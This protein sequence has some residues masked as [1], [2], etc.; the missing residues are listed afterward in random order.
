MHSEDIIHPEAAGTLDGLF[1]ERVHRSG[2][3]VAYQYHDGE[4]WREVTWNTVNG[5]VQ[6]WQRALA[7]E[8]LQPGD[9]VALL[10]PNSVDWVVAEQAALGLGLVVVPLYTDDRPDNV[11]YI[12]ED[13][14]AHLIV[15]GNRRLWKR[16]GPALRG[17]GCLRRILLLDDEDANPADPGDPRVRP[18]PEWL[19]SGKGEI[20]LH[21]SDGDELATIVYTSG[22]TGRPKGVMLSHRN[23][24]SNAHSALLCFDVYPDDQSL[25]FLPLSHTFER[26]AG[27]YVP[28]MAGSRVAYCRSIAQLAEDMQQI[29]PTKM[30]VVPR[31]FERIHARIRQQLERQSALARMLFDLTVAVG[32]R[33]FERRMG[34]AGW[35]PSQWLWP[36]LDRLVAGKIRQRLGGRIRILVSGGAA[37]SPEIARV[38]I[39]M[40]LDIVQG[41]GMTETSPVVSGNPVDDNIPSSVGVPLPGVEVRIGEGDELLVRSPGVML[42]YWNNHAATAEIIEPDGWLHTGD[43]ARIENR[44]IFITGRIKDILVMS[45]GEKVPPADMEAAILMH[46]LF[47]QCLVLGEGRSYLSALVVLDGEQW[48]RHAQELGVD[49]MDRDAL[50]SK[51]VE[52]HLC[53]LITGQLGNF[54]GYARIRRVCATLEPWTVDNGL[55]TPTMKVKRQQVMRHHAADIERLYTG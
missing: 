19:A 2:D 3:D 45:N 26:T 22:T 54:P 42:G 46:P 50:Q 18:V 35:R 53:R 51:P 27:Y 12:L 1:R 8:D 23:I 13:A 20:R 28:M 39:G 55:M 37:L 9:R 16:F 14:A 30:I 41:Y 11:A 40:G 38:F 5:Q 15:I 25:S 33:R 17:V 49:P 32:W 52:R 10:L 36:L 21:R 31:I 4:G 48:F 43:C 47:E 7:G 6:A 34:R 24:L 29:R 44:H